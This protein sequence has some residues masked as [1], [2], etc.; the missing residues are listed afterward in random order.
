MKCKGKDHKGNWLKGAIALALT[1]GWARF[2]AAE[3]T[4]G[5]P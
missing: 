3:G 2:A 4:E 5:N 1:L